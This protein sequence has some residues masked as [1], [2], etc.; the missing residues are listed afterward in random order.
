MRFIV[1][2]QL[3]S[4]E[5]VVFEP[6]S[7]DFSQPQTRDVTNNVKLLHCRFSL[8]ADQCHSRFKLLILLRPLFPVPS[9][10]TISE[11]LSTS[12]QDVLDT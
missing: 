8:Q 7:G 12:A 4:H 2:D 11:Y 9:Y 5:A 10:K 1:V 3:T 6:T